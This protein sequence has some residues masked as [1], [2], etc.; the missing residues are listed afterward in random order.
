MIHSLHHSSHIPLLCKKTFCTVIM[1]SSFLQCCDPFVPYLRVEQSQDSF[2][3][4]LILTRHWSLQDHVSGFW[5]SEL[6]QQKWKQKFDLFL[7][8]LNFI[9]KSGTESRVFLTYQNYYKSLIPT[10][11]CLWF[12]KMIQRCDQFF[13]ILKPS[14]KEWKERWSICSIPKLY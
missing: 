4:T 5:K 9:N 7:Q 13:S 8:Y 1:Y 3:Q 10:R 14:Q 2:F 6:Y 11:T 12:S